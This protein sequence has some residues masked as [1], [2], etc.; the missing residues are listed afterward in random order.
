MITLHF[1]SQFII[2]QNILEFNSSVKFTPPR[3]KMTAL[4][5]IYLHSG[6][7]GVFWTSFAS[8][9]KCSKNL[10][11]IFQLV[12]YNRHFHL[13]GEF[14]HADI[15]ITIALR[16]GYGVM[17]KEFIVGIEKTCKLLK[18]LVYCQY[19]IKILLLLLHIL[20]I[21]YCQVP[22]NF[23]KTSCSSVVNIPKKHLRVNGDKRLKVLGNVII[24]V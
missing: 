9:S 4:M 24:L 23:N 13:Y 17:I 10:Q 15:S 14:M 1:S 2:I 5:F 3:T 12:M 7:T 8:H 20:S 22:N 16:Q 21:R 6:T 18:L 19:S 11:T